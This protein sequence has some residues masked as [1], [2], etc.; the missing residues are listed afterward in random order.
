[1]SFVLG[2]LLVNETIFWKTGEIIMPDIAMCSNEECPKKENCYRAM[3]EPNPLWQSYTS[4][5]FT[6]S[7]GDVFCSKFIPLTTPKEKE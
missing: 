5:T 1:L 7:E 6:I 4:F 2:F 3:A